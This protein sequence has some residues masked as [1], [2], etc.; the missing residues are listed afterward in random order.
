MELSA[1]RPGPLWGGEHS[2]GHRFG[3]SLD[4]AEQGFPR[5]SW[6]KTRASGASQGAQSSPWAPTTLQGVM[7]GWWGPAGREEQP[8]QL[9]SRH[10]PDFWLEKVGRGRPGSYWDRP[11]GTS[12]LPTSLSHLPAGKDPGRA[13]HCQPCGHDTSPSTHHTAWER[14]ELPKAKGAAWLCSELPRNTC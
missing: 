12:Q 11:R 2:V 3:R 9:G 1:A 10:S 6:G 8:Q 14:G 4:G 7:R 13:P 5:R